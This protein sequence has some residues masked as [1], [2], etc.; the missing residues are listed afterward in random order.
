MNNIYDYLDYREFLKDRVDHLKESNPKFSYRYFN[1]KAGLKSS[2]HLKQIIDGKKN[3]GSKGLYG[4][5]IG[6]GLSEKEASFLGSLVHFNQA[7]SFDEKEKHYN[8]M[9]G[10]Y[11]PAHPRMLEAETYKIF[12]HWYYAAILELVR[13]DGF[14]ESA[15]WISRMLKPNIPVAKIRQALDD[16]IAMGLIEKDE[17]GSLVRTDKM[18]AA[19]AAVRSVAVVKYQQQLSKLAQKSIERDAVEDKATSTL[20]L[21]LSEEGFQKLKMKL[22]EYR[23]ELRSIIEECESDEKTAVAH[24]NLQLFKLTN[25]GA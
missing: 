11:P 12:T 16:L 15:H 6:L 4:V 18:I 8:A 25:G 22:K 17:S 20:T 10:R 13:L 7:D 3:L 2:G 14:R 1:K 9:I 21:A 24:V 5:C 19:P 23:E